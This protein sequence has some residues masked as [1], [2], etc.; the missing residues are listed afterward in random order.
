MR[1]EAFDR[2]AAIGLLLAGLVHR[3]VAAEQVGVA[4]IGL[5]LVGQWQGEEALR[6]AEDLLD[7][8]RRHRGVDD[9][10][11]ADVAPGEGHLARAWVDGFGVPSAQRP[12]AAYRRPLVK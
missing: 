12:Y 6:L 7:P 9:G 5:H 1:L 3:Q 4:H 2:P 8:G 11:E 10:E